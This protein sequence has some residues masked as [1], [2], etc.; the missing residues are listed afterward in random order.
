MKAV[1]SAGA[2][3]EKEKLVPWFYRILQNAITDTYR[4]RAV[5]AGRTI[6]YGPDDG[7]RPDDKKAICECIKDLIPI[8]KPEYAEVIKLIELD[9]EDPV[10][11][12]TRLGISGTNL[13]VRT[14][15]AR[16]ALRKR[17]ME[18]CRICAVHHCLDCSC[19]RHQ[20]SAQDQV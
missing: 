19:D 1:E 15:R 12:A 13:K 14:H 16:R 20:R 5:K 11:V 9:E 7:I 3:R 17:L 6:D 4:R 10:R 18:T 2:V 8:L